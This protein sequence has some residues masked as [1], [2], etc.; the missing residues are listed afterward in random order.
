MSIYLCVI[1]WVQFAAFT[2]LISGKSATVAA[3]VLQLQQQGP[4]ESIQTVKLPVYTKFGNNIW[5]TSQ[6]IQFRKS[7]ADAAA[8]LQLQQQYPF[9]SIQNVELPLCT[10]LGDNEWIISRIIQFAAFISLMSGK[11][12]AAAAAAAAAIKKFLIPWS[13]S[14]YKMRKSQWVSEKNFK[15]FSSYYRKTIGGGQYGPP[16]GTIRVNTTGKTDFV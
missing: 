3:A 6:I 1:Y 5:I 12:A 8:M 14:L 11:S 10:N 15:W 16:P 7:A 4:F 13:W 2:S 9:E